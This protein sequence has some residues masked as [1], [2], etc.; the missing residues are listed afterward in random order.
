MVP[1][2]KLY[3]PY[4]YKKDGKLAFVNLADVDYQ[5]QYWDWYQIP[6]MLGKPSWSEPFFDKGAGNIVM[7]TYSVPFYKTVDGKPVLEGIATVDISL[8]WLQKTV[9]NL[10]VGQ[11]GYAFLISRNGTV[12]TH[13]NRNLIMNSSIFS[14]AEE[15]KSNV[16]REIGRRMIH[17][18]KG[19]SIYDMGGSYGKSWVFYAPLP[20]NHWS[21]GLVFPEKELWADLLNLSRFLVVI[22]ILGILI[23]TILVV[24]LVRK[25]LQPLHRLASG[26]EHIGQGNFDAELPAIN[27]HDEIGILSASF[28]QMQ[29]ALK[30][31]IR[32]LMNTTAIREKMESELNIAHNIQMSIIPRTF[33]PFPERDDIDIYAILDPAKAVGGDWYDFF[34]IDEIHLCF[35]IGDVSGK[36]VPAAILMAVLK[37]FLRAKA[38]S[39]IPVQDIVAA[40]NVEASR[41]NE[42]L[43]FATLFIGILDVETGLLAYCNASHNPPYRMNSKIEKMTNIHG[44][45][46][47]IFADKTYTSDV[48]QLQPG[49]TLLLY[50]DG[51]TEALNEEEE[52]F[53]YGRLGAILP[54]VENQ[55]LK[56][57]ADTILHTLTEF[58]GTAPQADDIT[59]QVIRYFG[60]N[61]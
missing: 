13:P 60:K 45:A 39:Q 44:I 36:G 5:Y 33:P 14:I 30:E 47:G 37:T 15:R 1:G 26:A 4:Y 49:D 9:S 16:L 57:I 35:V 28:F 12:V 58:Q 7:A 24:V 20:S 43:M 18:E 51:V 32:D 31:Y 22:G 11:G 46:V 6:K 53:G 50:T 2:K 55:D 56:T 59:I 42:Y 54:T 61:G 10:K 23:L 17:G 40:I 29:T 3:A 34:F 48:M 52:L 21:L 25:M 41:Q 8:E 19:L 38:S 27:S